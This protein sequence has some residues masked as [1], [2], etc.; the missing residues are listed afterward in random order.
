VLLAVVAALNVAIG[1]LIGG[2]KNCYAVNDRYAACFQWRSDNTLVRIVVEP[3]A[4]LR[5]QDLDLQKALSNAEY[6][7]IRARLEKVRGVGNPIS[8]GPFEFGVSSG[9]LLAF[10]ELYDGAIA[11]KRCIDFERPLYFQ[12]DFFE[13]LSGQIDQSDNPACSGNYCR[14]IDGVTFDPSPICPATGP[15]TITIDGERYTL[16]PADRRQYRQGEFVDVRAAREWQAR[17]EEMFV[18]SEAR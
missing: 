9:G 13:P 1:P 2:T 16:S 15:N 10:E 11:D 3:V 6:L 18:D 17:A 7:D 8:I 12:I 5:H 4:Y 14:N